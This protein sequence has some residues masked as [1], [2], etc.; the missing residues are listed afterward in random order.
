MFFI[1][2]MN[3]K[4]KILLILFLA[5]L[6]SIFIFLSFYNFYNNGSISSNPFLIAMDNLL[7]LICWITHIFMHLL[8][9][10]VGKFLTIFNFLLSLNR[11]TRWHCNQI[12]RLPNPSRTFANMIFNIRIR[13]LNIR[14]FMNTMNTIACRT[15]RG[16]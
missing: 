7:L 4:G 13:F 10:E 6:V 5:H 16:R 2:T 15:S 3:P 9:L 8:L 12:T 14:P 11:R 1:S